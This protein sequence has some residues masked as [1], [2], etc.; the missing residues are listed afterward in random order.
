MSVKV[1]TKSGTEPLPTEVLETAI[2]D[3]AA[4]MRKLNASR[5]KRE[6]IIALLHDNSKVAKGTI[7]VILNNLDNLE[8]LFLKPRKTT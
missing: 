8:A 7:R 5:L 2:A 1:I 3:L 6:T 4:A